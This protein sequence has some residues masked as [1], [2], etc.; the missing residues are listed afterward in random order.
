M[1]HTVNC[2]RAALLST[3]S[4]NHTGGM[5]SQN[6]LPILHTRKAPACCASGGLCV[7]YIKDP[8]QIHPWG[9][10]R[11]I[12]PQKGIHRAFKAWCIPFIIT[13]YFL[14]RPAQ[15]LRCPQACM[16]GPRI[17]YPASWFRYFIIKHTRKKY[18]K[19]L[20]FSQQNS[21]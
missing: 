17:A 20:P 14:F 8:A 3:H 16:R 2:A 13:R 15:I 9:R 11:Q 1:H 19:R 10:N 7:H 21:A 18:E 6:S 5:R 4:L 12:D